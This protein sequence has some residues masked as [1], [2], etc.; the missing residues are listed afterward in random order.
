MTANIHALLQFP[1]LSEEQIQA[2]GRN[3]L[4]LLPH[5]SE[6]LAGVGAKIAR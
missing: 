5:L 3:A 1:D 2:I 6:R 4:R